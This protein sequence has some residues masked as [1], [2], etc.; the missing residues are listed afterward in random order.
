MTD[1]TAPAYARVE[2]R[3][4]NSRDPRHYR[5]DL[6]ASFEAALGDGATDDQ[7]EQVEVIL[8][9]IFETGDPRRALF[10][11]LE[12]FGP[13]VFGAVLL[14]AIEAETSL[15][16]AAE[17]ATSRDALD[18]LGL[19]V[20]DLGWPEDVLSGLYSGQG[21]WWDPAE[22]DRFRSLVEQYGDRTDP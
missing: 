8:D 21:S 2:G 5:A 3:R 9:A 4:A 11:V 10:D 13:K 18:C 22:R 16:G 20:A 15:M 6:A 14:F 12:G 7:C 19:S 17:V 1:P